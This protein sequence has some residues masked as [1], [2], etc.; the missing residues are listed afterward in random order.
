MLCVSVSH[1]HCCTLEPIQTFCTIQFLL[2]LL[3]CRYRI[4]I[5]CRCFTLL[6]SL[7][8]S[9]SLALAFCSAILLARQLSKDVNKLSHFRNS[10]RQGW[11][12]LITSDVPFCDRLLLFQEWNMNYFFFCALVSYSHVCECLCIVY[13]SRILSVCVCMCCCWR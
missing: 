13:F 10:K 12:P 9:C 3:C 11:Q 1:F 5:S 4:A 8:L 7:S 2:C 6:F